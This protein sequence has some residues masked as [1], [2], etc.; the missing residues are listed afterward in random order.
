MDAVEQQARLGGGLAVEVIET[1]SL[2]DRSYLATDGEVAVVVD[3]Q[4]DV[5]RVIAVAARLE[6]RI[7]LVL[8]THVHNDYV[9]GGLELARLTGAEYGVAAA[10]EVAFDRRPLSD[11]D[12]VELSPRMRVRVMAT[13][14]HTFHH[15]SY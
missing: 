7:A 4:R 15:L 12:A 9:S 2:G 3:P 11:G 5:D 1:S 8:E 6:V 14:G 10:D 13:P